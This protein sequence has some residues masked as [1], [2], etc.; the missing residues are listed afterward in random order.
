MPSDS[1]RAS[2]HLGP[3]RAA[4]EVS[5]SSARGVHDRNRTTAPVTLRAAH[6]GER[7]AAPVSAA[8]SDALGAVAVAAMLVL[9]HR[10]R[11][12]RGRRDDRRCTSTTWADRASARRSAPGRP[13]AHAAQTQIEPRSTNAAEPAPRAAGRAQ[14]QIVSRARRREQGSTTAATAVDDA[15]RR[16]TSPTAPTISEHDLD[17]GR[18]HR[19]ACSSRRKAAV[20]KAFPTDGEAFQA[21]MKAIATKVDP[22]T[23]DRPGEDV[24]GDRARSTPGGE[25]DKRVQCRADAARRVCDRESSRGRPDAA[26]PL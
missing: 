13:T 5:G 15:R 9:V 1:S 19:Q 12:A 18:R 2:E 7:S 17:R 20:A 16:P 21:K 22:A 6:A 11:V 10:H 4:T 25:L 8:R 23:T 26:S 24:D 3:E 14:T